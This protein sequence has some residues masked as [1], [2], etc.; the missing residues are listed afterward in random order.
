MVQEECDDDD[1]K[2]N[3]APTCPEAR[4][5]ICPLQQQGEATCLTCTSCYAKTAAP[6]TVSVSSYLKQTIDGQDMA[7]LTLKVSNW[8]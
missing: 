5:P 6:G 2:C 1:D 8:P 3:K 7:S 4:D